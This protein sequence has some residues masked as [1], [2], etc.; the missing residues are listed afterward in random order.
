MPGLTSW[1]STVSCSSASHLHECRGTQVW[2]E[3]LAPRCFQAEVRGWGK[4]PGMQL[5]NFLRREGL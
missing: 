2:T 4:R 3:G 1:L 5:G